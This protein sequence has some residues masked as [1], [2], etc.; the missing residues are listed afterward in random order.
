MSLFGGSKTKHWELAAK[1]SGAQFEKGNFWSDPRIFYSYKNWTSRLQIVS[2]GDSNN[3][4]TQLQVPVVA[5]DNLTFSIFE[6]GFTTNIAKFFNYQDI[7]I[8]DLKFDNKFIIKSNDEKQISRLLE[9]HIIKRT[10]MT[11][12]YG[13]FVLDNTGGGWDD[14]FPSNIHLLTFQVLG[15]VKEVSDIEALFNLFNLTL[16]RLVLIGSIQ[17]YHPN[18]NLK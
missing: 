10:L 1:K 5:L 12:D 8:N 11:F 17:H 13:T 16:N 6:E 18:V 3:K 7:Q 2:Q 15:K 4:Y 14:D 9:D